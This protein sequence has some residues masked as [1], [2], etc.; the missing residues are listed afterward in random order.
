MPEFEEHMHIQTHSPDIVY[1][2]FYTVGHGF[3]AIKNSL[4]EYKQKKNFTN[5]FHT[6]WKIFVGIKPTYK[7]SSYLITKPL[8]IMLMFQSYEKHPDV[9][10]TD[11]SVRQDKVQ[12]TADLWSALHSDENFCWDPRRWKDFL[13]VWQLTEGGRYSEENKKRSTESR[14]HHASNWP[15]P[16]YWHVSQCS[17]AVSTQLFLRAQDP[18]WRQY[19]W[20]ST[21]LKG[22]KIE[23]G[24]NRTHIFYFGILNA[25][26]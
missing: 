3:N 8:F 22:Y 7:I 11:I 21:A 9:W 24:L 25:L 2:F 5:S 6:H 17:I 16:S 18:L 12:R 13:K 15:L 14:W 20:R 4:E 10:N 19:G 23:T 26:W 1:T